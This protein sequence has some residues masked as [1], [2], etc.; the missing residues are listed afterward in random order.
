MFFYELNEVVILE[1]PEFGPNRRGNWGVEKLLNVGVNAFQPDHVR[2]LGG[3]IGG[4]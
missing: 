3:V 1:L 2:N 4:I